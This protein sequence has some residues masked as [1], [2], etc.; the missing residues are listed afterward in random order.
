MRATGDGLESE[1]ACQA[2]SYDLFLSARVVRGEKDKSAI[3]H[4][5]RELT[6]Q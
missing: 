4:T 2:N 6:D 1:N 3:A 5:F